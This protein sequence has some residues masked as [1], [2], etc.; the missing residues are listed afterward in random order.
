MCWH[1]LIEEFGPELH[2]NIKGKHNL[3]AA[4]L[5]RIERDTEEP[6]EKPTAQCMAVI[7][8]ST[9]CS[10]M[11]LTSDN[12]EMAENF[13]IYDEERTGY[14]LPMSFPY[15]AEIQENDKKL[16]AEIKKDNHKYELKKI[17][18]TLVSTPDGRQ[19]SIKM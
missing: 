19:S 13:G 6:Q 15:N 16:M 18:R 5:S 3:I 10:L 4:D 9:E 12:L 1:L 8:G 17:E 11:A 14:T 2:Y 7:L